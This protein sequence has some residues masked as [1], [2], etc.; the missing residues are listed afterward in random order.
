MTHV[1]VPDRTSPALAILVPGGRGQLGRDLA[2]AADSE[3]AVEFLDAPGSGELDVTDP[4][5]VRDSVATLASCA[6]DAR[7]RPVVVNAAAYTAVDAAES[8]VDTAFAVN[9]EGPKLLATACAERNVPLIHISTDYVFAGDSDHPYEPTGPT[10]PVSVYGRSKLGGERAVLGTWDRS[11]VVRTSWV[12][13]RY[14]KNF[15]KTICRL[16]GERDILS[17]VDDQRG[18]PTWT[19]DLASGLLELARLVVTGRAPEQRV[20]HCTNAGETTWFGFARAIFQELGKD[21]ERVR[22][23]TTADFPLPAPRPAYS[24]LSNA[25]WSAA[26]LTPLRSWQEALSAAFASGAFA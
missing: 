6:R 7:A 4:E 10:S 25:S 22:P 15:V 9:A 18:S 2:V 19:A 21:P 5:A 11:W 12:Y 8:D 20:V 17:V 13:G 3:P 14:G 26:G 1:L 24:V 23:C 16:E